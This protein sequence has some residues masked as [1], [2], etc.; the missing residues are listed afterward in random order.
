[1]SLRE[2]RK[3]L[4]ITQEELA[5]I[6]GISHRTIQRHEKGMTQSPAVRVLLERELSRMEK[7]LA[8]LN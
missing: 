2:R 8:S 7:R 1:M 3:R 5:R 6:V 4:E